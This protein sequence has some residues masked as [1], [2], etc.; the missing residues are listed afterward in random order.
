M[1][2]PQLSKKNLFS[3]LFFVAAFFMF[4]GIAHATCR[5]AKEISVTELKIGNMLSWTTAEEIDNET[6]IIQKSYN[7]L[8]YID[9]WEIKGAGDSDKEQEYYYMDF[10]LSKERM[11]Y[12]LSMVDTK[13][14]I[15]FSKPVVIIRKSGNSDLSVSKSGSPTMSQYIILDKN[16]DYLKTG[17]LDP[18]TKQEAIA[19]YN[20]KQAADEKDG[21]VI[22]TLKEHDK[23]KKDKEDTD[24]R[25]KK[26]SGKNNRD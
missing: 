11:F 4:S 8:D 6:F 7:G 5:F 1:K 19:A 23:A 22:L 14:E 9:I 26:P 24:P 18:V 3:S 20:K 2:S 16:K 12:R 10:E 15:T 25:V 13:G 17:K 21:K